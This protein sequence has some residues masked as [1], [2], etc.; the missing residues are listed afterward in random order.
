MK[1]LTAA[2]IPCSGVP[3]VALAPAPA[4][5]PAQHAGTAGG[6]GVQPRG[7]TVQYSAADTQLREGVLQGLLG[8]RKHHH[9]KVHFAEGWG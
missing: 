3:A 8:G 2:R 4:P 5:A 1:D 6:G 7:P 9:V